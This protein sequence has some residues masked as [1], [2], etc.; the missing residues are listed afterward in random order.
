MRASDSHLPEPGMSAL[1]QTAGACLAP[2]LEPGEVASFKF[3]SPVVL[4]LT[5]GDGTRHRVDTRASF[6]CAA[7]LIGRVAIRRC[8]GNGFRLAGAEV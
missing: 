7:A 1:A 6:R 4:E 3:V 5:L 2:R 8:R